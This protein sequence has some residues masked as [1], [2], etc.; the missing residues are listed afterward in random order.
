MTER[1]R[2]RER[3]C[4]R[5]CACVR[6]RVCDVCVRVSACAKDKRALWFTTASG[7]A[8]RKSHLLCVY[9]PFRSVNLRDCS[10]SMANRFANADRSL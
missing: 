4:V 1:E 2:E 9:A 7:V 3:V 5:V 10:G 8:L 6:V